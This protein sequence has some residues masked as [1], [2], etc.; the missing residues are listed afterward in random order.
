MRLQL[1]EEAREAIRRELGEAHRKVREAQEARDLHRKEAVELRRGLSDEGKEKEAFQ[2]SNM[3]L[4]LALKRA[5][6]ERIRWGLSGVPR[7]PF[8]F[9]PAVAPAAHPATSRPVLKAALW[10]LDRRLLPTPPKPPAVPQHPSL[11]WRPSASLEQEGLVD[12][13]TE[14]G[15]PFCFC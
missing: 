1:L 7:P 5:E 2:R 6:S 3:E 13:P 15:S 9:S 10:R 11:V 4:R 8:A 12:F 14:D